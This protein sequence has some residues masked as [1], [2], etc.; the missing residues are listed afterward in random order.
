MKKIIL[1]ILFAIIL[2]TY[3]YAQEARIN[4]EV[5][6]N[7][8]VNDVVIIRISILNPYDGER[9]FS[10]EEKLPNDIEMVEP[11][12]PHET[13]FFNGI[14]A[15]FLKWE[16]TI[17]PGSVKSVEYKI[18]LKTPGEYS[19]SPT[20][21]IDLKS[22]LDVK[23]NPSNIIVSCIPN[24]KCEEGENYL[25]CNQDCKADV[26]DGIC[27]P[28]PELC[29]PDCEGK[30]GCIQEKGGFNIWYILIPIILIVIVFLIYRI[31]GKDETKVD[32]P[33][34]NIE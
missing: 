19:L 27:N 1:F 32:V 7:A 2:S 31:G 23:G 8:N 24:G 29:D 18:R 28:S 12:E 33:A 16:L 26:A 9:T 5:Q 10:I 14:K 21:V 6:S 17:N 30:E 20:K 3:A 15:S 11:S 22:K 25:N 13:R 4:R 34:E